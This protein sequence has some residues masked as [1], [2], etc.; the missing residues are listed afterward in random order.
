MREGNELMA[1][2]DATMDRIGETM[3]RN[4][5]AFLDLRRYLDEATSVL[6][7]LVSEIRSGK[8]ESREWRR[9]T[10]DWRRE[11]REWRKETRAWHRAL[12]EKLDR[13][14]NGPQPSGA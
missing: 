6:G 7:A 14:D 9:E 8:Q 11:T 3:N 12:G 2:I 10:Q 1:R 5:V 4:E 13:L